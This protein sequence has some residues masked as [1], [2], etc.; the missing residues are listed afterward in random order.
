VDLEDQDRTPQA[1]EYTDPVYVVTAR[2]GGEFL[3]QLQVF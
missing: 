3:H 1:D 2:K